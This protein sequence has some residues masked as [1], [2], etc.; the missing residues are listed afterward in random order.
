M[1]ISIHIKNLNIKNFLF[2]TK[3]LL[4]NDIS[5]A[6]LHFRQGCPNLVTDA[7]NSANLWM[8]V[9]HEQ[10][11]QNVSLDLTAAKSS[12]LALAAPAIG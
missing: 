8:E 12:S 10:I 3:K 11:A 5:S 9:M 7:L 6:C 2:E 1:Y 4:A